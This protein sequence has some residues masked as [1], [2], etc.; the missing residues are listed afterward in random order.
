[1]PIE[2][3]VLLFLL[4]AGLHLF[5]TTSMGI[6]L[7][8]LAR[9]MPQFGLLMLL[10]MMPLQMLSGGSTPRESMPQ[11]VQ[12]VMLAAPTT[13]FVAASQAI[14]YRGAGLDVVLPRMLSIVAIGF[15]FFGVSL[16]RFRRT[17]G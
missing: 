15:V 3:S 11:L 16:I 6:L 17:S 7:A 8:T 4:V 13:H 9:T 14:L 1:M 2:G 5:S 10:V 12:T